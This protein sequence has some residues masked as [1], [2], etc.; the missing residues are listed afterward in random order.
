MA[1]DTAASVTRPIP[2]FTQ[3]TRKQP[4]DSLQQ[5]P[6]SGASLSGMKGLELSEFDAGA[7]CGEILVEG[8]ADVIRVGAA[9]D[10]AKR[11]ASE[12]YD[13]IL[14]NAHKR[15]AAR[16]F[17][18]ERGKPALRQL[19]AAADVLIDN[20]TPGALERLGFSSEAI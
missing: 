17:G 16:D 12:T 6:D 18:A 11:S 9:A 2:R 3:R 8:G 20:L 1:V 10:A 5:R 14:L 19:V 15:S 7:S 4:M 13:Y